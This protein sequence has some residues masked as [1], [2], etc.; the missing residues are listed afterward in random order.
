MFLTVDV[1]KKH[2]AC[3]QGTEWFEHFFPN[4]GTVMEVINHRMVT[5]EI[6]HWGFEN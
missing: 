3:K 1:L 2:N 4:G 6:L 5:P